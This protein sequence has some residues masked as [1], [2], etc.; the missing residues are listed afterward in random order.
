MPSVSTG[1][2][3]HKDTIF[4]KKETAE[5]YGNQSSMIGASDELLTIKKQKTHSNK[6]NEHSK[7]N[8]VAS[9]LKWCNKNYNQKCQS[10]RDVA[11]SV[12]LL[13]Q[14]II[15]DTPIETP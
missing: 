1:A 14:K 9:E 12:I 3:N 10:N 8:L 2:A 6:P 11:S 5:N 7:D 4:D 15:R 13:E